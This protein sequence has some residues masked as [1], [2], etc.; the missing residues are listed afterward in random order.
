MKKLAQNAKNKGY[1]MKKDCLYINES[2]WNA[3]LNIS[4][5]LLLLVVL[6][7]LPPLLYDAD[8]TMEF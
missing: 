2:L 5:A 7:L 8:M 6:P 4:E 1:T 3:A